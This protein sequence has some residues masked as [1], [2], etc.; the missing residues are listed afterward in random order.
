MQR[1]SGFCALVG[2]WGLALS[3]VIGAV[4]LGRIFRDMPYLL[5]N[6]LPGIVLTKWGL[7]CCSPWRAG[8]PSR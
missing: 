4:L 6:R 8:A 5:P 7:D 2:R 1:G 3:L